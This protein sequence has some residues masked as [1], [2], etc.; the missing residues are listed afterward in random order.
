MKSSMHIL[1]IILLAFS[2]PY[3]YGGCVVAYSSGNVDPNK[4]RVDGE[5]TEGFVGVT[6]QAAI[7]QMNAEALSLGAF[8][9]G[10]TSVE[11]DMT[12]LNQRSNAGKI[13]VI[14]PLKFP[15]VLEESLRK[16]K[17]D[18]AS[19]ALNQT[20]IITE[21]D[22]LEGTCGGDFSYTLDLNRIS[23]Q[24]SGSLLF[25]DYCDH[26]IM[27]S[28]ETDVAGS[29]ESRTGNFDT[30]TFSFIDLSGDAKTID[31]EISIDFS[32][33]PIFSTFTA[34][35][36]DEPTG[37]IYWMKDYSINQSQ[38]FGHVE[39]EIFGTFYHPD[40]GFVTITTTEPFVVF[41]EDDWPASGQLE[42]Q[43]NRNTKSQLIAINQMYYRIEADTEGDGVFDKNSRTLNWTDR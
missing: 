11:P 36:K 29:F 9:G 38:F 35:S 17:V 42:I 12:K 13:D 24:F 7:T 16:I 28:G 20:D 34:Y 21:S 5:T 15:I 8:A 37:Q 25:K 33:T 1:F 22:I 40:E 43:G 2:M 39:I 14:R 10:L 26:G 3:I 31:G 30:A 6:S 41:D 32:D 27:V 4:E 23:N 19:L 18:P